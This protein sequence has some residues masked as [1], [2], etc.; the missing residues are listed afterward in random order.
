M[1]DDST[2]EQVAHTIARPLQVRLN[3]TEEGAHRGLEIESAGGE[4]TV[5][6]FR[7]A[8]LPETVDGVV[9]G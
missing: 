1:A 2:E 4:L 3:Q 8:V 5:L 9:T 6:R 7:F